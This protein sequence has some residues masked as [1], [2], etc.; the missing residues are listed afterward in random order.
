MDAE[1]QRKEALAKGETLPSEDKFDSN[2]ITPGKTA[3]S[4]SSRI[5][6]FIIG[7]VSS[8]VLSSLHPWA[9]SRELIRLAALST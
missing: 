2:C 6:F 3:D 8:T 7:R 9:G 1:A 4:K 5:S